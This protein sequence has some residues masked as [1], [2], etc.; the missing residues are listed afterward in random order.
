MNTLKTSLMAGVV[1]LTAPLGPPVGAQVPQPSDQPVIHFPP[2][3]P[4]IPQLVASVDAVV[5]GQ[6]MN[7]QGPKVETDGLNRES[8]RR[9]QNI[10]VLEFL[11]GSPTE[12]QKEHVIVRQVGG[13]ADVN[14]RRVSEQVIQRVLQ[15][16]EKAVLFLRPVPDRPNTYYIAYGPSGV[17][18]V[19]KEGMVDLPPQMRGMS[20]FLNRN[21]I[22]VNELLNLLRAAGG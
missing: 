19:D 17:L 1:L 18:V 13:A 4:T 9:Y 12:K 20:E 10:E 14:G 3:P 7:S 6:T 5:F 21:R 11:K 15:P 2:L 16:G 22:P 8:V